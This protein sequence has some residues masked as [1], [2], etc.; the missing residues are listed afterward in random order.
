MDAHALQAEFAGFP[1]SALVGEEGENPVSLY[2]R[3]SYKHGGLIPQAMLSTALGLSHQRVSQLVNAGRFATHKIGTMTF[4]TGESFEA[5]LVQERK[6]G[7]CP[8]SPTFAQMVHSI[9]EVVRE[10]KAK[11][12]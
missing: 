3:L 5:F 4:I 1:A 6:A 9:K 10:S 7:F 8:K 2:L 11:A 12:A